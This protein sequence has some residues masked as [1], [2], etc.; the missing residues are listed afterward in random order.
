[1]DPTKHEHVLRIIGQENF[2]YFKQSGLDEMILPDEA[3]N[4]VKDII[5]QNPD[6]SDSEIQQMLEAGMLPKYPVVENPEEK[7]PTKLKIKPKMS[8]NETG[9][10]ADIYAVSEDLDGDYDY[11]A[12]VKSMAVG[13]QQELITGRQ[14]A[15]N[16]LTSNEIVL[17]LLAQEGFRPKIKE[18]LSSNLED[19][20]LKDAE[21]FFEKIQ[22]QI[23]PNTGQP[24]NPAQAGAPQ[25]G[26]PQPN[27]QAQGLPRPPQAPLGG[28]VRK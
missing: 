11:I 16:I 24:I 13:A 6:T 26:G 14:N 27:Q 2:A 17:Q 10:V 4:A 1:S 18:L 9:D 25:M 28:G 22:N 3:A 20:G 23:D 12:D 5:V 8:V 19:L 15:I 21:R 7:N